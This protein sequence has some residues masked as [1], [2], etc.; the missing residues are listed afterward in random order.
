MTLLHASGKHAYTDTNNKHPI[1]NSA[2]HSVDK[3]SAQKKT[4]K[5][6]ENQSFL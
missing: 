1:L 6:Q 5:K 2:P 4:P 3:L